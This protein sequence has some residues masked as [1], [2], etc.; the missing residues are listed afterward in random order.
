MDNLF[1][2]SCPRTHQ[3]TKENRPAEMQCPWG[4]GVLCDNSAELLLQ[5][6]TGVFPQYWIRRQLVSKATTILLCWN[7]Q[8]GEEV[9]AFSGSRHDF[10]LRFLSSSSIYFLMGDCGPSTMSGDGKELM[11]SIHGLPPR[12]SQSYEADRWMNKQSLWLVMC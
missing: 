1:L 10:L 3:G 7:T 2:G 5:L 12:T 6:C 4:N 11:S 9:P 8:K